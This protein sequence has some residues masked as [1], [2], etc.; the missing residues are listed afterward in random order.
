MNYY[1]ATW[2]KHSEI[3]L[4][5]LMVHLRRY[6][7]NWD[8]IYDPWFQ[9]TQNGDFWFLKLACSFHY[10]SLG[11]TFDHQIP[12]WC[13]NFAPPPHSHDYDHGDDDAGHDCENHH[14]FCYL[15][16]ASPYVFETSL[17]YYAIGSALTE[18]GKNS[19]QV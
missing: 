3:S 5:G 6:Q 4:R 19:R 8:H 10:K 2:D 1:A 14:S 7:L 15:S 12:S 16:C 9:K 13:I 11:Q 17:S 18:S